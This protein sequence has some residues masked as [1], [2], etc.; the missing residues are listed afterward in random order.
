MKNKA[1]KWKETGHSM[2]QSLVK[3]Y[4]FVQPN[5]Q[6]LARAHNREKVIVIH[7]PNFSTMVSKP[8]NQQWNGTWKPLKFELEE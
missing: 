5:F 7:N 1:W 2:N 6:I 3:I 8:L 4:R